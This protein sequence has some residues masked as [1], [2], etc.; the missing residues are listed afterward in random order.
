MTV[1]LFSAAEVALG[2]QRA[3]QYEVGDHLV[4]YLRSANIVDG[5]LDL[6]DV[7][8]MNFTPSEQRTFSLVPGD[9]LIT[10]GSGSRRMVGTSAVWRGELTGTICFQN[11]LLRLRPRP[12]ITD[13]RYLAWWARHAHAAGLMASVASGANILHLGAENLRSLPIELPTLDVQRRIA[14]FLDDQ[15]S[16]LDTTAEIVKLQLILMSERLQAFKEHTVW[17]GLN[18]QNA[19]ETGIGPAPWAPSQWLRLRNKDLYRESNALSLRGN[20]ELL[21]VSHLT[22]VTPRSEKTVSMFKAESMVGYRVVRPGDLVINTLWAWMGALGISRHHGIVSPAYGVY[23]PRTQDVVPGYFDALFRSRPYVVEMTRYS[24]GVWSSRLRLYP[25]AFLALHVL[26]PPPEEQELIA[27]EID[28]AESH[29]RE[30]GQELKRAIELLQERK[31]ALITAAVTGGFDVSTAA[32][33]N[34]A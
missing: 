34:L 28:S 19:S 30:L 13:G 22:G 25:E 16:R 32:G 2:R 24:T 18:G 7:K 8:S 1:S 5:A 11:T 29:Q 17:R 31:N 23:T 21:S 15:V 26:M 6:L 12:G 33:R 14:D 4:P 27:A 20:E 3:P 10:E 9:V